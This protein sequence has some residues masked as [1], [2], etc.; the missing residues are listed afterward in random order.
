MKNSIL[1]QNNTLETVFKYHVVR[2]DGFLD[3]R[4]FEKLCR[5][6]LNDNLNKNEAEQLWQYFDKNNNQVITLKEFK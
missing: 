4:Y 1:R 3:F 5:D 2:D 6:Y